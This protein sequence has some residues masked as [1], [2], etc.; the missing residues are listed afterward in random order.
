MTNVTP[1]KAKMPRRKK[2]ILWSVLTPVAVILIGLLI[3]YLPPLPESIFPWANDLGYWGEVPKGQYVLTNISVLTVITGT[4]LI[5]PGV[6]TALILATTKKKE[7][8][9]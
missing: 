7:S 1:I 4:F 2:A 3:G 9:A 8:H 6:V 5:I